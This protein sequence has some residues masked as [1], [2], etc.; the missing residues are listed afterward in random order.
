MTLFQELQ[1]FLKTTYTEQVIINGYTDPKLNLFLD[2]QTSMAV[3]QLDVHDD[4]MNELHIEG[5][6]SKELYQLTKE[7]F[8]EASMIN[9]FLISDIFHWD[10]LCEVK[11]Q[12]NQTAMQL[13]LSQSIEI[14]IAYVIIED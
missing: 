4:Y 10:I 8:L 9:P 1:D 14:E 2:P 13:N 3:F 11:K 5:Q 12:L 6:P 7:A